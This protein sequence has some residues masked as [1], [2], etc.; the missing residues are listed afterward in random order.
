[1]LFQSANTKS[2]QVA[3]RQ[4]RRELQ[5]IG[6]EISIPGGH[7][8]TSPL[9]LNL[10]HTNR[11]NP[12]THTIL[13]LLLPQNHLTRRH[14]P[15]RNQKHII[16]PSP[17]PLLAKLAPIQLIP[18]H[19]PAPSTPLQISF[20]KPIIACYDLRGG[21][22]GSAEQEAVV[23]GL[24][25]RCGVRGASAGGGRWWWGQ[26]HDVCFVEGVGAAGEGGERGCR[27][28]EEV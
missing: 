11:R 24:R 15:P 14:E 12:T 26:R 1:M 13:L 2:Y 16:L 18:H 19:Q 7:T 28:E 23:I 25:C 17:P 9:R 5:T 22:D 8:A 10:R 21:F 3:K 4:Y 27:C 6:R 20:L